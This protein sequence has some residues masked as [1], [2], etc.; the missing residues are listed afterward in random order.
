M[1]KSADTLLVSIITVC[2]NSESTIKSTIDSV[3]NQTHIDIEYIVIDGQSLDDTVKIVK[4]YGDKITHFV[5]EPDEGIYDAMNKGVKLA[6]GDVVGIL[7]SDDFYI[8]EK[9]IA[10]VAQ[11]FKDKKVDSMFADLVS[12]KSDNL[13]KTVR[14]YD[15]SK[16]NPSMFAYGLTPPHPTFFVKR[17]MYEKYGL[18][19]TD[20]RIASDYDI[21]VLPGGVKAMEK[22]RQNQDI[23]NFITDFNSTNKTIA[24]ICSG[25]Q[26]LISAKIVKGRKIS[27]YYSM[28]DDLINAGAKYT[29]L[30]AVIDDNIIT[31]AH[32][33]DMGPWM[34]ATINRLNS[35]K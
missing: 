10:K 4:S 29:D 26:L 1:Q 31:T 19:R 6:T 20:L 8:D 21:L 33:K 24:C 18:F 23:I 27:G 13:K 2:F 9:V 7:N 12:V 30:P 14:Y 35:K 22:V 11:V 17:E 34:K 3:L 15:G 28:K 5:S 25:A 16:F 32:Y